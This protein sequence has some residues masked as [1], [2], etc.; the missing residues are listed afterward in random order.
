MKYPNAREHLAAKRVA[1]GETAPRIL[2]ADIAGAPVHWSETGRRTH[3]Q[4][5]RFA[6][7]PICNLHLR[8]FLLRRK[9]IEDAG[10]REI[11]VFHSTV[12]EIAKYQSQI[13]FT[14][15]ADPDK[16]LYREFGVESSLRALLNP[17]LWKSGPR[18]M[19]S[20]LRLLF[21][22]RR[23]PHLIPTGGPVG[24]PADFLIGED[25]RVLAA[26]YGRHAFDQWTVDELLLRA[27]N[28]TVGIE[29]GEAPAH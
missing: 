24:L 16:Q 8:S 22:D 2:L 1:P 11:I 3:V 5:R 19:S 21:I 10:V 23:M 7:C 27:R 29:S 13:P 4:F 15:I 25:G 6:G 9:E 28:H 20:L 18:I 17:R 14:L 26:K 12:T